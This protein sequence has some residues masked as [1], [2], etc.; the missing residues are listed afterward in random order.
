MMALHK[1]L[2]IASAIQ[3]YVH[4]I[5]RTVRVP[6]TPRG[7]NYVTLLYLGNEFLTGLVSIKIPDS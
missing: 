7:R 6:K 4:K 3:C 5:L 2:V 1:L